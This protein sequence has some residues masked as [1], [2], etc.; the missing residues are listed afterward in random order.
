MPQFY[1]PLNSKVDWSIF[2][3][4]YRPGKE[5]DFA[6]LGVNSGLI[7]DASDEPDH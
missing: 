3:W 1:I 5:K 4:Y 7:T 2:I 6:K